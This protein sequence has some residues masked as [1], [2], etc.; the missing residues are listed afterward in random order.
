MPLE[1][2]L[3]ALCR[4]HSARAELILSGDNRDFLA[5]AR[6]VEA[7]TFR[8][9]DA[10]TSTCTSSGNNS[11]I[12]PLGTSS[13]TQGGNTTQGL[14]SPIPRLGESFPLAS[15]TVQAVQSS[16]SQATP[17]SVSSADRASPELLG[18]EAM[19]PEVSPV[20]GRASPP[21]DRSVV[22]S[23]DRS[24]DRSPVSK[25]TVGNV[26]VRRLAAL[27]NCLLAFER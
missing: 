11:P 27:E 22:G 18:A 10:D 21:E 6:L 24:S 15:S 12:P 26:D 14:R 25:S 23:V 9:E 1:D 7:H 17:N 19:M 4:L 13:P 20:I 3:E 16:T 2:E 5:V 8:D